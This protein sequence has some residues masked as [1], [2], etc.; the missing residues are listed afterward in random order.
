MHVM[1]ANGLEMAKREEREGKQKKKRNETNKCLSLTAIDIESG[2]VH[3]VF[4]VCAL[5]QYR[6]QCIPHRL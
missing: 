3:F 4:T 6:I 2:Q 1:C 5:P